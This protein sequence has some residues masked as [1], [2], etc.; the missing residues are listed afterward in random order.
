MA[1]IKAH[2]VKNDANQKN[3]ARRAMRFEHATGRMAGR[4]GAIAGTAAAGKILFAAVSSRSNP[5]SRLPLIDGFALCRLFYRWRRITLRGK[6]RQLKILLL[7]EGQ[8]YPRVLTLLL[9]GRE[10]SELPLA[11]PLERKSRRF[12]YL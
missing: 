8:P 2:Y 1:S 7:G 4:C 11:L 5:H 10:E 3:R 6:C 9:G 12:F